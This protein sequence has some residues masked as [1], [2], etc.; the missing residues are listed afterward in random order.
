MY[1]VEEIILSQ[2]QREKQLFFLIF[3][4]YNLYKYVN[5]RAFMCMYVV[6][7]CCVCMYV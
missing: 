6:Y 4:P 5:S 1:K 2:H 3:V 7:V